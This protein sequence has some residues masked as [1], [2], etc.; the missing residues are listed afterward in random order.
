MNATTGINK[1][2]QMVYTT[3][4]IDSQDIAT[5]N[6]ENFITPQ[7]NAKFS[8]ILLK[9]IKNYS[10]LENSFEF[11]KSCLDLSIGKLMNELLDTNNVKIFNS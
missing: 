11:L 5:V 9:A 1:L 4:F 3:K 6:L 10:Q 8:E 2:L 7:I